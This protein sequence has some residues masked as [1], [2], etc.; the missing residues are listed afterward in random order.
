MQNKYKINNAMILACLL[1]QGKTVMSFHAG[2]GKT[3]SSPK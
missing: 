2:D 1:L 3:S